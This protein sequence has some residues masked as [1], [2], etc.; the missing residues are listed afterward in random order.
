MVERKAPV[1][2]SGFWQF[3]RFLILVLS[4]VLYLNPRL[5][6]GISL[7]L[8]LLGAPSLV[9]A[10]GAILAGADREKFGVLRELLVF[11][12]ALEIIPAIVLLVLQGGAIFFGIAKPV[13]DEVRLVD[14]L[15]GYTVVTEHV[16]YYG[17]AAIVLIDLIF[18]LVLL[19]Y[20]KEPED[21]QQDPESIPDENLPDY[22]VTEIDNE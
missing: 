18:L 15:A 21:S 22:E 16:F 20:K 12:K 9:L 1:I 8:V 2:I 19:S 7:L 5:S 14:V 6:A 13:F 11:G 17:L 10:A 4:S 3:I